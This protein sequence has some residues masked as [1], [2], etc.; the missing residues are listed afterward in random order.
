MGDVRAGEAEEEGDALP[1]EAQDGGE[2]GDGVVALG[3]MAGEAAAEGE[4]GDQLALMAG[5]LNLYLALVAVHSA[6]G[7]TKAEGD[8]FGEAGHLADL[9][10]EGGGEVEADEARGDSAASDAG[11]DLVTGE[12]H[13]NTISLVVQNLLHRSSPG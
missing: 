10:A 2:W 5:D 12:D 3:A 9:D 4:E 11:L 1:I 13:L 8:L 7:R 6:G